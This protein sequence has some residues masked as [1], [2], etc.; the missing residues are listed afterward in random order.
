MPII[1]R[2]VK[3]IGSGIGL[4]SEAIAH[5]KEKKAAQEAGTASPHTASRTQSPFPAA[6]RQAST[7]STESDDL[8]S[9]D[10]ERDDQ[11]WALDEAAAKLEPP[12][13]YGD[14]N[15][16]GTLGVAT[17]DRVNTFLQSHPW[18]S[19]TG[20]SHP[21]PCP[22]VLPQRRPKDK[23]RGFVRAYSPVL[24]ECAGIDE[25]TFIEFIDDLDRASQV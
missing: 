7:S 8:T 19:E 20:S 11:D 13:P 14:D 18:K 15:L 22:V 2:I 23:S 5:S 24:G 21:L 10:F 4:A 25:A 12:P 9:E 6:D 3:G 17:N 1:S 16:G